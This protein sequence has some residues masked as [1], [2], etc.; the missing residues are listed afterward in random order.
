[1]R[2]PTLAK[3]LIGAAV[4]GS[5]L[6]YGAIGRSASGAPTQ[7]KTGNSAPVA[8]EWCVPIS[9]EAAIARVMRL[10]AIVAPAMPLKQSS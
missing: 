10:S 8:S 9:R 5:A 1:V 2:L 3:V 4:I 7:N 6:V